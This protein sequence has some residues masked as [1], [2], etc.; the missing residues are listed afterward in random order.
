MKILMQQRAFNWFC[1]VSAMLCIMFFIFVLMIKQQLKYHF[2]GDGPFQSYKILFVCSAKGRGGSETHAMKLYSMLT[3]HDRHEAVM[4]VN[5]Q[6]KFQQ[7]LLAAKKDFYVY[8]HCK[9]SCGR[10]LWYPGLEYAMEN[11]CR[12]HKI[13][14]L[15]CND[16]DEV[17]IAC[18]V[19]RRVPV[20]VVLTKHLANK[21]NP[22]DIGDID[23]IIGVSPTIV[24]NVCKAYQSSGLTRPVDFIKPFFNEDKFDVT[25]ALL[26]AMKR[27][28]FFVERFG[29]NIRDDTPLI[30]VVA[31]FYQDMRVK[32]HPLLFKAI[33]K[34]VREHQP[35]QVVLA[36]EGPRKQEY[37]EIVKNLGLAEYVHFIGY[38]SHVEQLL[39]YADF[40]VLPSGNEAF[41]IALL[42]ASLMKKPAII[43][44]IID[45]AHV[46][47]I[48]QQTGL[49]FE[50]DNADSLADKISV[51]ASNRDYA[52]QLGENAYA[53]VKNNF[54]NKVSFERLQ[55]F[56][57]NVL[58]QGRPC[59]HA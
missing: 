49:L 5:D 31:H 32:N 29:I 9:A 7:D 12:R 16:A 13:K 57:N 33:K 11:I 38:A 41:G 52:R 45:A 4:L 3:A 21:V 20:K 37:I 14:I 2:F 17:K 35:V 15:H 50:N 22:A 55:K 25:T 44:H 39:H 48:D 59:Q 46:L 30:V 54:S 18:R 51:L 27:H 1:V 58:A 42:E 24:N 19:A 34:L 10:F 36:G 53:H 23:A 40:T 28:D 56:Y 43:S 8:K 6:F 26:P 47:V